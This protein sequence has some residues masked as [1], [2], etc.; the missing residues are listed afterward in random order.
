MTTNNPKPVYEIAILGRVSW[1]LHSLNNEGTIGNVVEPRTLKLADGTTTDGISGEMLKHVHATCIWALQEDKSKFCPACRVLEPMRAERNPNVTSAGGVEAATD[2]ALADCILCDLHGFLVQ[3]PT[4]HRDSTVQFGWAV[5]LRERVYRDIH[6]HARHAVGEA[7]REVTGEGVGRGDGSRKAF[8][9]RHTPVIQRSQTVYV[10]GAAQKESTDYM[11][12]NASGAIT[13][14]TAPASGVEV[15][16]DYSYPATAQMLYSRPT[17]SG[18]YALVS[19]FQPWRI[20]LNTV[21]YTYPANLDRHG[22]C[23]LALRAYEAMLLRTDGAMTS[24]RLPHLEDFEG[25]LVIS[26]TNFPVPVITP[27]K[28]G[29]RSEL[30]E[31]IQASSSEFEFKP[32]DDLSGFVTVLRTLENDLPYALA[33]PNAGEEA[34]A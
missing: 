34:D 18:T 15:T 26:R 9:L 14:T 21:D 16:A 2:R 23:K 12:D 32:F 30:Q 29:Y 17:R 20:G 27:L 1:N 5:G 24:T 7:A 8:T 6:Q 33:M 4:V 31:I 3:R 10:A 19:L 13:F 11:I 22:R 25:A 28:D